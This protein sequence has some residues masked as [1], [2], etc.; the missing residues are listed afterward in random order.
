MKGNTLRLAALFL[1]ELT[2]T[3]VPVQAQGVRP[4][5]TEAT[6][7]CLLKTARSY[8]EGLSHHDASAIPFAANVRCTEQGDVVVTNE[9][10]FRKEINSSTLILGARNLR[11]LADPETSSVAAFYILDIAAADGKPAY[12]VRR[13]QRF[14]IV[15][16]LVTEVEV[17]N[18]VDPKLPGLA[19]PLWPD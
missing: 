9:S 13:G 10:K 8:L 19:P 17:F 15:R 16:G 18:Y 3:A 2:V 5:C 1:V 7:G 6:R 12:T 11:M 4:L 14:K